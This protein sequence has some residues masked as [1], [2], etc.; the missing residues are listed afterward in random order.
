MHPLLRLLATNPELLAGHAQAYA[1]LLALEIGAA[2]A[3]WHRRAR[4][5]ACALCCLSVAAVLAGV[6]LML[7]SVAY[8]PALWAL[9]SAPL[10]PL[11]AGLWCLLA[12]RQPPGQRPFDS[13]RR[14]LREDLA[15]LREASV[16]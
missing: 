15:L 13:L 14:Q 7:W 9:L 4:L 11:A 5:Q 1:E 8:A 6:A 2:S 12:A 10:L 16:P 3:S